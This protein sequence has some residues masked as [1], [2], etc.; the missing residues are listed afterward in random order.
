MEILL[1]G[2]ESRGGGT[3]YKNWA[4]AILHEGEEKTLALLPR[5]MWGLD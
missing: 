4:E 3:V 1:T 2:E 5:G